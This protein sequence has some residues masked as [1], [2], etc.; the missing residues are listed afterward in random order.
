MT[1]VHTKNYEIGIKIAKNRKVDSDLRYSH[2]Y[3]SAA[4]D[5]VDWEKKIQEKDKRLINNTF[6]NL[7]DISNERT[8]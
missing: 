1:K 4:W 6:L 7:S 5:V 8:K 2:N 3:N